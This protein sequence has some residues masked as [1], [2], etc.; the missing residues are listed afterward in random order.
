MTERTLDN[1]G[2]IAAIN[3]QLKEFD[4]QL[5]NIDAQFHKN[6]NVDRAATKNQFR[7][8]VIASRF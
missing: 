3:E 7:L 1:G 6:S 5:A 2:G 4:K 8:G